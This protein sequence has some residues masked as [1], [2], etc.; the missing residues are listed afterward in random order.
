MQATSPITL[1][2]ATSLDW[3]Q[4]LLRLV[5]AQ[6][7]PS[8]DSGALLALI[9]SNPTGIVLLG[10]AG[11]ILLANRAAECILN[12]QD[13]LQLRQQRLH[14]LRAEDDA[15]LQARLSAVLTPDANDAPLGMMLGRRRGHR[16]YLLHFVQLAKPTAS[17]HDAPIACVLI[18]NPEADNDVPP[19]LLEQLFALTPAEAKVT[20]R[21]ARGDALEEVAACLGLTRNAVKYHLKTIYRKTQTTRQAQL[22]RLVAE[23]AW[24]T[25]F[26]PEA[27]R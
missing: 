7:M 17:N 10:S 1:H 24:S 6:Y 9:Q 12:T 5:P 21:V 26:L 25:A 4:R 3:S 20:S 19:Q 14:A 8:A 11:N 23:L 13:A 18:C 16:D 22:T 15:L 27:R 2:S